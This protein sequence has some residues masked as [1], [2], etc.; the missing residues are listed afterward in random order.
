MLACFLDMKIKILITLIIISIVSAITLYG[1]MNYSY[2]TG[3]RS[4]RLVKLTEKGFFIKTY[5]GT[6]DLGTGDNLTWEFTIRSKKLGKEL[7]PLTGKNVALNYRELLHP[8][9]YDTKYDILSYEIESTLG[10]A[11]EDFC[12]LVSFVRRDKEMVETLRG[13]LV[14]EA[15]LLLEKIKNCQSR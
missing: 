2:S 14:T 11:Q 9:I 12:K 6:L 1:I 7:L 3:T 5:E 8:I 15:P 10:S 4:G 13:L